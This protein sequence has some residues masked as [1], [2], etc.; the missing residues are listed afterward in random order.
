MRG[1]KGKT[2]PQRTNPDN[3]DQSARFIKTA[4]DLGADESGE[5]FKRALDALV[6][7]KPVVKKKTG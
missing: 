7:R 3:P 5:A 4:K 2:Q 6:P 1:V